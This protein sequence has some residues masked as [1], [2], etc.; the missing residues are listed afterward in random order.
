MSNLQNFGNERII[1]EFQRIT[2]INDEIIA[3]KILEKNNWN[4]Q[5]S[6][7]QY[8][9]NPNEFDNE[10]EKNNKN[11]KELEQDN[12]EWNK[13]ENENENDENK[14]ENED[15]KKLQLNSENIFTPI[16]NLNDEKP[17]TPIESITNKNRNGNFFSQ[18][19]NNVIGFAK[20]TI[21]ILTK[22]PN[23]D[24]QFFLNQIR[25]IGR[26]YPQFF[27]GSYQEAFEL[28]KQNEKLLVVYLHSDLHSRTNYFIENI[29]DDPR[30]ISFLNQN[31]ILWGDSIRRTSGYKLSL[32]L[33]ARCYPF[34]A[35][36][37]TDSSEET[38]YQ[39]IFEG[40][41]TVNELLLGLCNSLEE[42]E[43]RKS[44]TLTKNQNID[45]NTSI[46]QEQDQEFLNSLLIDRERDILEEEREKKEK[47]EEKKRKEEKERKERQKRE[48]ELAWQKELEEKK[49][50]LPSEPENANDSNVLTIAIKL[51]NSQRIQ[52]RFYKQD[53]IQVIFDWIYL[54]SQDALSDSPFTL[55]KNFPKKI[56]DDPNKTLEEEGIQNNELLYVLKED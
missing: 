55:V 10:N 3:K 41:F 27:Q 45:S 34:L 2:K 49:Q 4:L 56:F 6:I 17:K 33:E 25:S 12:F 48:R 51:P 20:N 8:L 37:S 35:I 9:F 1:Q 32:I 39:R 16:H 31:F 43:L 42:S 22:D 40:E 50:N 53:K 36:I 15:E 28:A 21:E 47:E 5:M 38:L 46:I 26:E 29:L 14:S 18:V 23:A 52:R 11:E 30:T 13:N 19:V 7:N 54:S 44:S 24:N